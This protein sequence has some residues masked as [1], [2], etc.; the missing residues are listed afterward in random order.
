MMKLKLLK[1]TCLGS[2]VTCFGSFSAAIL[3]GVLWT[4]FFMKTSYVTDYR[5]TS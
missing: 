1:L 2:L 4:K 3:C 5:N